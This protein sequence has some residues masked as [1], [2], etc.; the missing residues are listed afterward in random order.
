MRTVSNETLRSMKGREFM[1]AERLS[2]S[3]KGPSS[4]PSDMI[5][6]SDCGPVTKVSSDLL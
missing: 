6:K 1:R 2:A 3:R 5:C 4:T